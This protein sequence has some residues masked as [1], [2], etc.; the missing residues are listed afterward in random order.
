MEDQKFDA[1]LADIREKLEAAGV[2][3]MFVVANYKPHEPFEGVVSVNSK[4]GIIMLADML[5]S[6]A[7]QGEVAPQRIIERIC[8]NIK[9]DVQNMTKEAFKY[10]GKNIKDT[11]LS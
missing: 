1:L 2:D 8:D 3:Y 4:H 9:N 5:Y 6:S 7:Q 11:N 10:S